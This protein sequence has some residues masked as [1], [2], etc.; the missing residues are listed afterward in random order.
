[1]TVNRQM[2]ES[3]CAKLGAYAVTYD[4]EIGLNSHH[5]I[6]DPHL[7]FGTGKSCKF[8]LGEFERIKAVGVISD[9]A[10]MPTV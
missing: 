9:L 7:F 2:L 8:C 4:L 1:M 6:G 3:C 5:K 10:I